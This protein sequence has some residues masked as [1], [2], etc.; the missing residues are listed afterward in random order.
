VTVFTVA[1]VRAP[2]SCHA[3]TVPDRSVQKSRPSG[4]KARAVAKLAAIFPLGGVCPW[5]AQDSVLVGDGLGL[6]VGRDV[7]ALDGVCPWAAQG[8]LLART[9]GDGLELAV[10]IDEH[11]L[12]RISMPAIQAMNERRV[13]MGRLGRT[14]PTSSCAGEVG[15]PPAL[16]FGM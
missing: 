14:H 4:A 16:G 15:F 6:A 3:L 5:T 9:L 12:S 2:P 10:G 1:N 13:A 11:A 7:H 8:S